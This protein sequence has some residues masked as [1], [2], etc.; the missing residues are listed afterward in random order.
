MAGKT[1][2]SEEGEQELQDTLLLP[3]SSSSCTNGTAIMRTG[4]LA[5]RLLLG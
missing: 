4:R 3:P 1:A 5:A 2:Q